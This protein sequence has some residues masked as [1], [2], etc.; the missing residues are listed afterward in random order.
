[1][2][3]SEPD[4]LS[5]SDFPGITIFAASITRGM[6]GGCWDC[7]YMGS[8]ESEASDDEELLSFLE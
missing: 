7:Y 8:L 3:F 1:M 6:A 5:S 4:F 2:R